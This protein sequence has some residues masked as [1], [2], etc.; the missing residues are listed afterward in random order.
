MARH[1]WTSPAPPAPPEPLV[2]RPPA[3]LK[4][5]W[6]LPEAPVCPECGGTA[7]AVVI[8]TG[9]GWAWG[10]E[11]DEC[12]PDP[13]CWSDGDPGVGPLYEWPFIE[14]WALGADWERAGVALR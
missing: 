2:A 1:Q 9:D 4:S 14:D 3:T 10:W 11:C 7:C 12:G 5:G 6:A 8:H 13:F